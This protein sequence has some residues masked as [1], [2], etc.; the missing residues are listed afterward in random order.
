MTVDVM[1]SDLL[2]VDGAQAFNTALTRTPSL[3]PALLPRAALAWARIALQNT[4]DI[5]VPGDPLVTVC[6]KSETQSWSCRDVEGTG[7]T[8]LASLVLVLAGVTEVDTTP[9][10]TPGLVKLGKSL[11]VTIQA[12]FPSRALDAIHASARSKLAKGGGGGGQAPKAPKG[13]PEAPG[14]AH[15]P[16]EAIAAIPPVPTEQKTPKA[17]GSKF[18]GIKAPGAN[19]GGVAQA[20]PKKPP[21]P[22]AVVLKSELEKSCGRCGMSH[23]VM[24]RLIGCWCHSK[25][26]AASVIKERSD[27]FEF[28]ASLNKAEDL[29][30]FVNEVRRGR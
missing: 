22:K 14:P 17:V 4:R 18:A 6:V 3:A 23:L 26:L 30:R 10:P 29:T 9:T 2:G 11:D 16:T 15:K 1:L 27:S 21:K 5:P 7:A 28:E 20:K 12:R 13:A 25:T 24:G 19:V 8:S